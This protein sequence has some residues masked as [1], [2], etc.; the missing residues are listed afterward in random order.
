[1]KKVKD[2]FSNRSDEYKLNRPIYPMALF[3]EILGHVGAYDVCWDC[4]TGSGQMA[5]SIA[6]KFERVVATDI[7]QNQ[8]DKA[9]QLPN[10]KYIKCRAEETPIENGSVNLIIVGQAVHWFD[11]NAFYNEVRRV[12]STE[13]V[14]ALIGYGLMQIDDGVNQHLHSFC[15][16]TL[17]TYWDTERS[18][19]DNTY[20][21]IPFPFESIELENEHFIEDR[22]TL[23]QFHG[24]LNTWSSVA[25]FIQ[26]NGEDPVQHLISQLL[27]LGA[28]NEDE[29]KALRFPL[30]TKIGKV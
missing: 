17:G 25:R 20:S 14:I 23:Q 21:T 7:S 4:A 2:N 12:A 27:S 15:Y 13:A 30:F 5:S 19:I 24:Y 1:M 22:W 11:F 6:D 16:N 10:V 8:L 28:W 3:D 26:K 18:H 29:Q 9:P